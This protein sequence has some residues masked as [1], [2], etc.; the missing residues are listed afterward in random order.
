MITARNR[1]LLGTSFKLTHREGK[2]KLKPCKLVRDGDSEY[3][4]IVK[5]L[6][7]TNEPRR[8][9]KI[10]NRTELELEINII[11]FTFLYSEA[12]LALPLRWHQIYMFRFLPQRPFQYLLPPSTKKLAFTQYQNSEACLAF[13]I[14][15]YYFPKNSP[16]LYLEAGGGSGRGGRRWRCSTPGRR[17]S[18]Y[19]A[20]DRRL[21]GERDSGASE[22]PWGG[23]PLLCIG[24]VCSIAALFPPHS[25][26]AR[27]PSYFRDS[28]FR[29]AADFSL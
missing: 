15:S 17:T 9:S 6:Q 26:P 4:C 21:S 11:F 16:S 10:Y 13:R 1:N 29:E 12:C 28:L 5:C 8:K 20:L 18:W 25:R 24:N 19:T 22:G 27:V 3:K 2:L 23:N 14:L 7:T